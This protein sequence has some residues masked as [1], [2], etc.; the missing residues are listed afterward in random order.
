MEGKILGYD[1]KGFRQC[2]LSEGE[3][4]ITYKQQIYHV[5][6]KLKEARRRE[7]RE[8]RMQTWLS[9]VHWP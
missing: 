3:K 8:Q 1:S 6:D 7:I 5:L 9:I 2:L 4:H